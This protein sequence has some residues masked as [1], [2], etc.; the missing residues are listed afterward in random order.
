MCV[1]LRKSYQHLADHWEFPGGKVEKNETA[2]QALIREFKEELGIETD[3]WQPFMVVPWHYE[4]VSVRLQVFKTTHFLG[5]PKGLEGQKVQWCPLEQLSNRPFPKANKGILNALILPDSYIKIDASQN[6][7]ACLNQFNQALR[8]G[9]GLAQFALKGRS[10]N[11]FNSL[12]NQLADL[13]LASKAHLILN[14]P[15]ESL[16]FVPNAA[17]IQ[18]SSDHALKYQSRPISDHKWL[19]ISVHSAQQVAHALK[20][21]ADVI[22]ISPIKSSATHP[23]LASIDWAGLASIIKT[24]PVPIYALGGLNKRDLQEAKKCGAQGIMVTKCVF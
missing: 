11:A 1:S 5:E 20:L 19:V 9:T 23:D 6:D 13:A 12:A 3:H 14:A 17:G 10:Q 4:Q 7:Q 22:L 18:L 21:E 15:P 8:Q 24:V 16:D 2:E